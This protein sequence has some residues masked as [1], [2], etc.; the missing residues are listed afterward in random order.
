MPEQDDP[1]A[2]I[3]TAGRDAEEDESHLVVMVSLLCSTPTDERFC[4]R[5]MGMP[6]L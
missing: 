4:S 3:K 1:K 2:D 6:P 5:H